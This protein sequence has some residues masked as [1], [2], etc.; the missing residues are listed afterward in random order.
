MSDALAA[1]LK[2]AE[3]QSP[4][5]IHLGLDR[6]RALLADLGQPQEGLRFIHVAG[7][8]GKGSVVAFL[9]SI[10]RRSG[11]PTAAY[12]SPH[13]ARFN[14]RIRVNG[15]PIDDD[16]LE[17]LLDRVLAV[18]DGRPATFFELTTAAA[19][20][21]FQR[22]G[23][24]ANRGVV[25]LETGLGGRL[26]ATNVITPLLSLVTAIGLDHIDFLGDDPAAIAREKGGIFKPGVPACAD[27]VR[28]V[29]VEVLRGL[30]DGLDT[31]LSLRGRDYDFHPDEPDRGWR[32]WDRYGSLELPAPG[33]AGPHQYA[34]AALA[35]AGLRQLPAGLWPIDAQSIGHGIA[36]TRWPGRLER[37]EG[38]PELLLDGAHNVDAVRA[39]VRALGEPPLRGRETGLLFSALKDKDAAAMAALLAPHVHRVWVTPLDHP[40]TLDGRSL[41]EIWRSTGP[42]VHVC[43]HYR[44]ALELA[45]SALPPSARILVTGSLV[46]V[47]AVRAHIMKS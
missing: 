8:N 16:R 37:I 47:G 23:L 4:R 17:P 9:E 46:L 31:P 26:D 30:A 39:L 19:L 45:R 34:N 14:E 41:E 44:E 38:A 36:E 13:L 11:V 43:R 15:R 1:L 21:H 40:Q 18:N 32:Y 5:T 33:L 28:P 12:T 3:R 35:V 24:A 25:L 6:V 22:C 27:P 7:T 20:C 2:L 10:L 29:A 42:P